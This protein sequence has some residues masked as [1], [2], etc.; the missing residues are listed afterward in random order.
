MKF[1]KTLLTIL[2]VIALIVFIGLGVYN[3]I[4]INQIHAVAS[5]NRSQA[6]PNPRNWVLWGDLAGVVA[7]L[8]L[9]CA[10][11]MPKQTF[12]TR[13][14]ERRKKEAI[15]DAQQAGFNGS[16]AA[17]AQPADDHDAS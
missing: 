1:S 3:V 5:A 7:G 2:G 12:K 9:G 11:A 17:V 16:S 6:F 4:Q 8:L 10:L 14:K 13:Y 15:A